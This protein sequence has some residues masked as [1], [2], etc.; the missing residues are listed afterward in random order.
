TRADLSLF[1]GKKIGDLINFPELLQAVNDLA[2]DFWIRFAT[3]HP[4]DMSDELIK[5]IARGKKITPYVHLPIQAGDDQTLQ[6]MNRKYTAKHYLSLIAKIR[7]AIPDAA[8]STDVIVGFPGETKK[9]FNN[10][11]KLM[12]KVKFDMAYLAQ[13]SPRP[14]TAA[15]KLK[16]NVPAA[17]KKRREQILANILKKTAWENNKK[18]LN[19]QTLVLLERKNKKGEW[20]GKNPQYKT[21]K[22]GGA[23]AKNLAGEFVRVKINEVK[24]FGLTGR[25]IK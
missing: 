20:I 19:K 5:V 8:I 10:T 3:S 23:A 14:G 4:K 16:D 6:A 12:E 7:K 18:F 25:L 15:F 22:V 13:Y 11:A 17:E 24:D 9:Q 2:G 21:V 1:S